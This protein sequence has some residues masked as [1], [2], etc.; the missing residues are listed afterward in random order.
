[1]LPVVA[2]PFTR[3]PGS[4]PPQPAPS[5]RTSLI[6]VTPR[7]GYVLMSALSGG[8]SRLLRVKHQWHHSA[9]AAWAASICAS[10]ATSAGYPWFAKMS[11]RPGM[12][13]S[14]CW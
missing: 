10:V 6:P 1:M 3:T 14:L 8:T 5:P 2:T 9:P 13:L 4:G 11:R 7:I 12:S